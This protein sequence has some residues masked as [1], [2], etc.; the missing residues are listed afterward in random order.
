[1]HL[2]MYYLSRDAFVCMTGRYYVFL[3]LARDAYFSIPRGDMEQLTPWIHEWPL[4]PP[5]EPSMST[6]ASEAATALAEELMAVGVLREDPAEPRPPTR[7]CPTA[8]SDLTTIWASPHP[9]REGFLPFATICASLISATLSLHFTPIGLIVDAIKKRKY[10]LPSISP[11]EQDS[12]ARLT[13]VFLNYRPLFPS[14]YRCLFDSLALIRFLSRFDLYPDWV[15]GVRGDP[16]NA[17]CWIQAGA[18][19]LNDDLEHVLHYTPIMTV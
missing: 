14:D 17:H 6:Q 13:G 19:V 11:L 8:A 1:M 10:A 9:I 2:P 12:A 3:D 15:F 7:I 5:N 18:L 4:A 16:F